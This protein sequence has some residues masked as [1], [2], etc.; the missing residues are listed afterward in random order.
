MNGK[1][2]AVFAL[3]KTIRGKEKTKMRWGGGV[4]GG[5]SVVLGAVA[6]LRM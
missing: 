4:D 5:D 1:Y 6:G 3:H 2:K